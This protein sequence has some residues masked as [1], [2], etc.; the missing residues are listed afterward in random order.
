MNEKTR[1]NRRMKAY[2]QYSIYLGILLTLLDAAMFAFDAKAAVFLL[3]YLIFYYAVTLLLYFH[4]RSIV[5]NEMISFATEYG[6]IQGQLLR[7]LDLPHALLDETG[8]VLWTN[9]AFEEVVHEP[10]GY[11]KSITALFSAITKDKLPDATGEMQAQYKIEYEGSNYQ[12]KFKTLFL[13]NMTDPQE[14]LEAI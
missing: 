9:E 8:K 7:E 13:K 3:F 6:Q 1:L 14:M 2:L 5:M 11:R 12:A 10:K 4:N